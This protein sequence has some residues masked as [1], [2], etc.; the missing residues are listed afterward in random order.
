MFHNI[1]IATLRQFFTD[2]C[3]KNIHEHHDE[4]MSLMQSGV[5][6]NS[7]VTANR[8]LLI[9]I[10][11]FLSP[12]KNAILALLLCSSNPSTH[13]LSSNLPRNTR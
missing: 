12:L 4:V 6:L 10:A 9:T 3:C 2:D 13:P 11:L 8:V 5:S 7:F 1:S